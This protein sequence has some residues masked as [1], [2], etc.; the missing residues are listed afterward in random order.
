MGVT[1]LQ[2]DQLNVTG[3]LT[4]WTEAYNAG[5]Q[6][7]SSFTSTNAAS[8]VNAAL[9]PKGTGALTAHVPDGTTTG[10]N[11][12][13]T[14]AVDW[15]R[16]RSNAN[17]VAEG[18]YAVIAG[19]ANN[20]VTNQYGFA[21][22]VDN[23]VGTSGGFYGVGMGFGN[24]IANFLDGGMAF[25]RQNYIYN[26]WAVALGQQNLITGVCAFGAGEANQ[27]NA[28]YAST[29]GGYRANAALYGQQA[30]ASGYF[31]AVGDAQAHEL[32]FRA[33][34]TGTAITELFLNGSTIRAILPSTNTIWQGIVD[35]VAVTTAVGNG[36]GTAGDIV[37]TEYKVTIKRI[38]TSTVIVGTV[39]EIGT[40]NSD[41]SMSTSVFTL[42]ADDTNEA[43]RLRFTPPSTSGTTSTYR[44]VATFRG[45]QIRY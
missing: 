17:Q 41:T 42:D 40:T 19:G 35:I 8:N 1:K 14:Y 28:D 4:N 7:T 12:R 39:Q 36:T 11:S 6:S 20:R 16:V 5:T 43:L 24:N 37:G 13:G 30:H 38:G 23:V 21:V 18:A 15:Q 45:T 3:G 10:G 25:G 27:T 2:A 22:G 9:I 32:V 44:V 33:S 31:A 26:N 29:P 34:V